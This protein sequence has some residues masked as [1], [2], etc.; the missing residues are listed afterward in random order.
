MSKLSLTDAL[1]SG[2][3]VQTFEKAEKKA[4]ILKKASE[5]KKE[6]GRPVVPEDEKAKKRSLYYTDKE[7]NRIEKIANLYDMK[8]ARWIKMIVEKELRKESLL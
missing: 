4:K 1:S 7:W 2:E 3:E 6:I 8:P 5:E